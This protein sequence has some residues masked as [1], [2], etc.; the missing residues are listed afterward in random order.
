MKISDTEGFVLVAK[1][2]KNTRKSKAKIRFDF[3]VCDDK[4]ILSQEG[5]RVYLICVNDIIYKIGYSR[6]KN[7]I[8][9]TLSFYQS[10]MGGK[11][12]IRT[13]GVHELIY[14]E[15]ENSK[16][17]FVYVKY[18]PKIKNQKI[19][20]LNKKHQI[21]VSPAHEFENVC[22]KDYQDF[23]KGSYPKWNY[24]EKNKEWPK[25]IQNALNRQIR[26]QINKKR[27]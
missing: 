24:Q 10:A 19:I 23:E 4:E 11:P 3:N 1:C 20:G 7:G 12:S 13:F 22:K 25:D 17:V 6:S 16:N 5:G 21:D 26:K 18:S 27:N 2:I 14:R 8:K 15:L 9:G